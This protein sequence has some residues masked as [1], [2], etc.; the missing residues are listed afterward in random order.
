M[1]IKRSIVG[2]IILLMIA[3]VSV[4]AHGAASGSDF[5]GRAITASPSQTIVSAVSLGTHDA[6]DDI[7]CGGAMLTPLPPNSTMLPRMG[8]LSN[9]LYAL[10]NGNSE[11][12][13]LPPPRT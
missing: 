2:L 3:F 7:S 5:A 6:C 8:L 13:D 1:A 4:T 11:P 12:P 9:A 10:P